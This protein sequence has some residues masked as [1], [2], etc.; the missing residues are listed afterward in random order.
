[1]GVVGDRAQE[2]FPEVRTRELIGR[3]MRP[4]EARDEAI[5]LNGSFGVCDDCEEVSVEN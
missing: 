2:L 4:V 3:E 5:D 1:M